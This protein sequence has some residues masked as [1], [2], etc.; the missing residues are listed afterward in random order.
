MFNTQRLTQLIRLTWERTPR[1]LLFLPFLTIIGIQLFGIIIDGEHMSR[2]GPTDQAFYAP[3]FV[4]MVLLYANSIS[5]TIILSSIIGRHFNSKKEKTDTLTLPAS[6]VER[7]TALALFCYLLIPAFGLLSSV[8]AFAV[9]KYTQLLGYYPQWNW[10]G[11]A[12]IY[13]LIPYYLLA[14]PFFVLSILRPQKTI[15]WGLGISATFGIILSL[16]INSDA[17]YLYNLSYSVDKLTDI[18]NHKTVYGP[19][20]ENFYSDNINPLAAILDSPGLLIFFGAVFVS[21]LL[22]SGWLGIKN[23]QV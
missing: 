18:P 16:I 2:Y 9:M 20:L 1:W 15:F 21:T 14:S 8:A 4:F 23:H 22:I 17:E 7:F 3:Y 11:N 6:R 5:L 19:I 10:M 13:S 12:F